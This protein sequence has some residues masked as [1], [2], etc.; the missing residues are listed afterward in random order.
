M[1]AFNLTDPA[2]VDYGL[3]GLAL[4]E[5]LDD[6]IS[7][8]WMSAITG[9]AISGTTSR[10]DSDSF[11]SRAK[12]LVPANLDH[13]WWSPDWDLAFL[14]W[15]ESFVRAEDPEG[16]MADLAGNIDAAKELGD[17]FLAS[18]LMAMS[19]FLRS[20]DDDPRVLAYLEES[21][22]I[23]VELGFRHSLGHAL[24]YWG[25]LTRDREGTG[26]ESGSGA[27]AS[28][29][30]MLAEVGDIS[31]AVRFTS[32]LVG[33]LLTTQ[34]VT[35]SIPHLA[36]MARQASND[37]TRFAPL[38]TRVACRAA[39]QAGDLEVAA[40]ILGHSGRR[41][42]RAEK[43]PF[44]ECRA[45]VEAGLTERDREERMAKGSQMNDLEILD[46]IN[47]WAGNQ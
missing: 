42:D 37:A 35:E 21:V 1:L 6:D 39:A 15:E 25:W 13:A 11:F 43:S 30:E 44:D 33:H 29:A 17:G 23:L 40:V 31:C 4:A 38:V 19:F 16:L 27:L 7:I 9:A 28:G 8:G 18:G 36:F 34:D 20:G 41:D 12:E 32:D 10:G 5:T 22:R 46:F 45:L 14:G 26:T 2:S 3:Q 24:L 47:T